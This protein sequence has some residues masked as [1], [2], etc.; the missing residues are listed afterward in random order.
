MSGRV[1]KSSGWDNKVLLGFALAVHD[2]IKHHG[3]PSIAHD[4]MIGHAIAP[5][6]FAAAGVSAEDMKVIRKMWREHSGAREG[7]RRTLREMTRA[8]KT[9]GEPNCSRCNGTGAD[10]DLRGCVCDCCGGTGYER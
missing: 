4:L 3:R 2:V 9:S 1:K 6:D 10:P 7:A 8:T 5:E